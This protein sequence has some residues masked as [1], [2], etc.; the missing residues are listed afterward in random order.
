VVIE[1]I[2][3]I[4]SGLMGHGIAQIAAMAGQKV[5]LIDKSLRALSLARQKMRDS[6]IRLHDKGRLEETPDVILARITDSTSLAVGVRNAQFVVEAVFED[7]QLKRGLLAEVEAAAPAGAIL[8]TNTSGLSIRAIAGSVKAKDRVIGMHWMNPPQLMKLV[9][10]IKSDHTSDETLKATLDL[11]TMYGKETVIANR[12]VWFFLAARARAGFSIENCA[13]QL[14]GAADHRTLDAV[15][16][17][18]LGLPMGEFELLDFTGAVDIR[19]KGWA[20]VEDIVKEY[21]DFEPWSEFRHAYGHLAQQVWL[22]MSAQRLS[23]VKSGRGFYEYPDSRYVKPDI[24]QE[25]ADGMDPVQ[26]MAPAINAAAWCVTNGVGSVNDVNQSMRL[27]FGWPKGI[28]DY[29]AD[30]GVANIIDVLNAKAEAAPPWLEGFY[31]LD[32]LLATWPGVG[33]LGKAA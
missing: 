2:A 12:D 3:V 33:S 14:A 31:R 19:P 17:Y 20:S 23:G 29:I 16:R 26:I 27:A 28:F 7:I 8:A 15:A 1:N 10:V 5:W 32:P 25:L 24:P 13:L 6:L 9:E 30:Y 11:C 18:K 4:G 22:P 21:P